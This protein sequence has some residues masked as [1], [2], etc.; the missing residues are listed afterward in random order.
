MIVSLGI[1]FFR[2][3]FRFSELDVDLIF[4]FITLPP[5]SQGLR[6]RGVAT[7]GLRSDN[8]SDITQRD[9]GLNHFDPTRFFSR[10]TLLPIQPV[11]THYLD[12][13]LWVKSDVLSFIA[14]K[15]FGVEGIV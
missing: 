4:S 11:I 14:D 6:L 15:L 1:Y 12:G 10:L 9:G 5:W 2:V 8:F 13:D 7:C 3:L